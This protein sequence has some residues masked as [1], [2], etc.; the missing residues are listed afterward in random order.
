MAR[1]NAANRQ[2]HE[3]RGLIARWHLQS[4][5]EVVH[6]LVAQTGPVTLLD[7]GCGE[8]FVADYLHRRNPALSITGIDNSAEAIAYAESRFGRAADFGVGSLLK[9]PY[10]DNSFDTVVCSEVLEHIVEHEVAM[11]ELKRVARNYVVVSVPNE[12][13]FK[14]LNDFARIIRFSQDPGHVNFWTHGQFRRYMRSHFA[15]PLFWRKHIMYQF[16]VAALQS[17][18]S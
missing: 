12:P 5:L 7:A 10:A 3:R 16:A 1:Y 14:W 4:V 9:L 6:K 15:N 17:D 11:G 2:K 18:E 13:Y 8:G